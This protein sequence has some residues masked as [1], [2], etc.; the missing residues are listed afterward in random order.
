MDKKEYL[1]SMLTNMVH[2]RDADATVDFHNYLQVKMREIVSPATAAP[3]AAAAKVD[4]S[5]TEN[6]DE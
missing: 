1:K 2:D 5:S 6:N 3:A 4:E